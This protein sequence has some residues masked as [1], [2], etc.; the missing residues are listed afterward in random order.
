M[1]MKKSELRRMFKE[2]IREAIY[3]S[4]GE[5]NG[6][7]NDSLANLTN[8]VDESLSKFSNKLDELNE[9]I[10][11]SSDSISINK[12]TKPSKG[13]DR[14]M[15]ETFYNSKIGKGITQGKFETEK[16]N[17]FNAPSEADILNE[18]AGLNGQSVLD[19]PLFANLMKKK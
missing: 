6:T 10:V 19:S 9:S 4:L 11:Q 14:K 13:A 2:I 12:D 1:S 17:T 7:I 16:V 5:L 8:T 15:F 18:N 3:E